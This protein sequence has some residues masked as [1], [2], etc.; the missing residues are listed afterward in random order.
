M[1]FTERAGHQIHYQVRGAPDAP[2]LLCIMGLALSSRAWDRLPERLAGR[3]RVITFDNRGTGRSGRAGWAFRMRDLAEDAASVLD[4]VG[5]ERAGVFGISMGGMIAQELALLHPERVS[6]LALGATFAAW[7]RS[8]KPGL[9]T[10]LDLLLM[11]LG[12]ATER[13]VAR[14]LVSQEWQRHHPRSALDWILRA[15]ATSVRFALAQMLAIA[16]HATTR[17]LAQIAAPTLILT[18]DADKLVPPRNSDLLLR[19]IPN[20]RLV[21]LRGAGHAFPLEREE[22]TVRALEQHFLG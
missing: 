17:R 5:A 10:Q 6:K 4:A 12:R 3:F 16:R 19:L 13:R 1:P 14:V 8:H 18:G 11:N 7:L 15:E 20:S 22:E 2:P 21:V 9:R